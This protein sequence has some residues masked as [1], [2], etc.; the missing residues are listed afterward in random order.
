MKMLHDILIGDFGFREVGNGVWKGHVKE[1]GHSVEVHVR[2]KGDEILFLLPNRSIPSDV[3]DEVVKRLAAKLYALMQ[4]TDMPP[5]SVEIV[6]PANSFCY[7]CLN[8]VSMP[9]RCN[10]CGGY[11]CSEHRLPEKHNC[12]GDKEQG[13]TADIRRSVEVPE[14]QSEKKIVVR[15]VACG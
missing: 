1:G 14:E 10:R 7:F 12:P 11:F 13:A 9:F 3:C 8:P 4:K 5:D 15:V 2:V 6:G